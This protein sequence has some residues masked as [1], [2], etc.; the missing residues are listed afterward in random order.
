VSR[1]LSTLEDIGAVEQV[2]AGGPY[3]LGPGLLRMAASVL[4]SRTIVDAARPH[5]VEL[6]G[7]TGEA[8]GLSIVEGR[9]VHYL[10]QVES[11]NAIQVRDWTGHRIP[12]HV[13]PSG[14]VLLAWSSRDTVDAYLDRPLE[15]P[16][17]HTV[18][19]HRAIRK[20]LKEIHSDGYCWVNEEFADGI[21]SIAAPVRDVR[22]D[23]VAAV[24]AHGP[25]YRFPGKQDRFAIARRVID[26]ADRVTATLRSNAS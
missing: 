14:L 21:N 19:D 22:G 11:R 15:R 26:A 17:S 4:P 10:D 5:L 16:T 13:V 9:F 1:L 25:T 20:R 24:H 23:V 7:S 12:L 6:M 8:T 2:S 3:R 18:I